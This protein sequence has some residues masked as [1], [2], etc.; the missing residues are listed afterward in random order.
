M[1][2]GV[3]RSE[4]GSKPTKFLFD[5]CKQKSCRSSGQTSNLNQKVDFNQSVPRHEPVYRLRSLE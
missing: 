5:M 4:I 1:D 2:Q 3:P